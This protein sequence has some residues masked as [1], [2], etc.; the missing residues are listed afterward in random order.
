M[1]VT[2]LKSVAIVYGCGQEYDKHTS[3]ME[4]KFLLANEQGHFDSTAVIEQMYRDIQDEFTAAEIKIED[5]QK[6][7]QTNGHKP[8]GSNN[9]KGGRPTALLTQQQELTQEQKNLQYQQ[10]NKFKC[11][12]C[13]SNDHHSRQCPQQ[14]TCKKCNRKHMTKACAQYYNKILQ[15]TTTS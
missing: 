5:R 15:Q 1:L 2:I 4:S 10:L 13:L 7:H 11:H 3:N 12:T 8:H 9:N 14:N 6:M